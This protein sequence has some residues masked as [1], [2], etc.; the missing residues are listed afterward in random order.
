MFD[1]TQSAKARTLVLTHKTLHPTQESFIKDLDLTKRGWGEL[2][3]LLK[4]YSNGQ[5][6]ANHNR[7][8]GVPFI[9][10]CKTSHWGYNSRPVR[11][12]G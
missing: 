7:G 10:I 6:P 8:G 11:L 3:R 12:V 1:T 4:G 2:K 9:V 5:K